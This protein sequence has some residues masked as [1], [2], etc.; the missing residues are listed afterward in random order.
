MPSALVTTV[1]GSTSNSYLSLVDFAALADDGPLAA[2]YTAA[3]VDERTRALLQATA[4]LDLEVWTGVRVSQS[5]RLAWPRNY[6]IDPDR[7]NTNVGSTYARPY[8]MVV[9]L[10]STTIPDRIRSGCAELALQ[11][12]QAG[13]GVD[14]FARDDTRDYTRAKLDVLEV[15]YAPGRSREDALTNYPRVSRAITPLLDARTANQVT[16][17]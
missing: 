6:A 3:S 7:T 9:Y 5:Q 1:G 15:E 2:V 12:L 16:R 14:L 8:D 13:P 11:I 4:R 10:P 17:A